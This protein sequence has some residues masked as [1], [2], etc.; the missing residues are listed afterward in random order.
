MLAATENLNLSPGD[1]LNTL[2]G[3][4]NRNP[5]S[6][7]CW[8]VIV[9]EQWRNIYLL[10]IGIRT[11]GG[12]RGS[13]WHPDPLRSPNI[14]HMHEM[15]IMPRWWMIAKLSLMRLSSRYVTNLSIYL[16]LLHQIRLVKNC[17]SSKNAKCGML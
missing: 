14:F 7:S 15:L 5:T 4:K 3:L 8:S 16:S 17:N 9:V 1:R 11:G 13:C 6:A 2:K 12:I 10:S